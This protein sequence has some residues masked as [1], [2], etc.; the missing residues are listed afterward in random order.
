VL[1]YSGAILLHHILRNCWRLWLQ[2][3]PFQTSVAR[4]NAQTA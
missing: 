4:C 3:R 2:V 1:C